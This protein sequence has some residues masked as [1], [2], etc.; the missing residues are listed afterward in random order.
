MRSETLVIRSRFCGPPRSANGGY[1]CGRIAKYLPGAAS[2][3][4]K[5]PPPIEVELRVESTDEEAHLFHESTLIGEAKRAK[6]DLVPPAAPSYAEA[7]KASKSYIGFTNHAFPRCFVCGPQRAPADGM[8]IFPGVF[9]ERSLVAA[10]WIPDRSLAGDS[11]EVDS[12]FIWSALDC[13]GGFSVLPVPEGKAILL[14]ELCVR[15]DGVVAPGERCVVV[16]W[17]LGIDGR[18][19]F[20]GSAI[21]SE[22]GKPVAV[23]R[24]TWIEIPRTAFGGA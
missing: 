5:A 18:K 7:E 23:A 19:R 13:S 16:G 21:Y 20:A 6:L 2:V 22:V 11:Q 3:R 24:A 15:I 12:E 4:L 1:V 9:E 10:P 14:G 17:S 8:R